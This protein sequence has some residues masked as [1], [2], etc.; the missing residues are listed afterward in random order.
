MAAS[1]KW[2]SILLGVLTMRHV[3]LGVYIAAPDFWK[4]PVFS[5]KIGLVLV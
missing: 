2:V 4:L 3:F 1:P 5:C